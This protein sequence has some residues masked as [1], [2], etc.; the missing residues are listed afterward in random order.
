MAHSLIFILSTL[1]FMGA[2][3]SLGALGLGD[4]A[5][6]R[7]MPVDAGFLERAVFAAGIGFALLSFLMVLLGL[8]GDGRPT[9]SEV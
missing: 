4:R 8:V 5:G 2:D 7:L 9:S 6:R 1:V 3:H